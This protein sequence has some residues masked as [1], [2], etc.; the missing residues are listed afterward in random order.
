[1]RSTKYLFISS[2]LIAFLVIFQISCSKDDPTPVIEDDGNLNINLATIPFDSL[3]TYG[4]FQ[5]NI[6]ALEPTLRVL[7]Y[8]LNTPLFSDYA[9]KS[10]FIYLPP[11]TSAEY[12]EQK[13][14]DFPVGTVII[15]NFYYDNDFRDPS[16][17]RR[18]LETRLLIRK[19]TEWFP[20]TYL[21]NEAQTE[22]TLTIIKHTLPVEWIH[23]DGTTR[24]LNYIVPNKNDCKG[25]HNIDKQLVPIGPQA[26][27]LNKNYTYKTGAMNQL[28]KWAAMGYLTN[29]PTPETAPKVPDW[30][31]PQAY[32]LDER[33][34]AYLDINCGHCH[35]PQGPANNSGLT[36]AFYETHPYSLGIC[37]SPIAAGGGSGNLRY[38]IVPGAPDESIMVFRMKSIEPDVAMPELAR[39]LLHEEGIQLIEDWILSL[40][41]DCE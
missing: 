13:A 38:N 1:M 40:E 22:A 6:A 21:W 37:K 7:P 23:E 35:N 9:K 10:R 27:H 16:K 41:G 25:C 34:R 15:K 17:G 20:A 31:N 2:F 8:D 3:S 32:S 28:E 11:E 18:I 14:F 36:L 4:F 30:T 39:S 5:G 29:V 24:N 26:R 12:V 33:A 19:A